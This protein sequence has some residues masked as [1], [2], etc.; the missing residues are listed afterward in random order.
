MFT[1]PILSLIGKPIIRLFRETVGFKGL[2]QGIMVID[3][4]RPTDDFTNPGDEDV[5][6]FSDTVVVGVRLHVECFDWTGKV[7]EDNGF[8][9]GVH[10]E[11]FSSWS[12]RKERVR[13][14]YLLQCPF[15]RH[16]VRLLC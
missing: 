6:R 12:V 7:S 16:G 15:Q 1:T 3:T 4:H 10:H 5:G 14:D 13:R 11:S 8:T 9:D 2:D